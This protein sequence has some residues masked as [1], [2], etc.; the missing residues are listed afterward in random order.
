[1]WESDRVR[2]RGRPLRA[3][4]SELKV[5]DCWRRPE[6]QLSDRAFAMADNLAIFPMEPHAGK[7]CHLADMQGQS[8]HPESG[9]SMIGGFLNVNYLGKQAQDGTR[10]TERGSRYPHLR[11]SSAPSTN[12]TESQH[13]GGSAS[14]TT[15]I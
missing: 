3:E 13:K 15:W 12:K 9:N 6:H 1:M 11:S 2:Q 8:A 4:Q 10:T 5:P 7:V 14:S